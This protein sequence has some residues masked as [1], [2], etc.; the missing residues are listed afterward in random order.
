MSRA[1]SSIPRRTPCSGRNR[2]CLCRRLAVL[3]ELAAPSKQSD[4][5]VP[6]SH[7][8]LH[9]SAEFQRKQQTRG[10]M[11]WSYAAR[12]LG[13][14]G[15]RCSASHLYVRRCSRYNV[16]YN[17][18][19]LIPTV[20]NWRMTQNC[21]SQFRM[22]RLGCRQRTV[23]PTCFMRANVLWLRVRRVQYVCSMLEGFRYASLLAMHTSVRGVN[24]ASVFLLLWCR[25][26]DEA[27]ATPC[28][29]QTSKQA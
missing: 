24:R 28:S 1:G 12:F 22:C 10:V 11:C 19:R 9:C 27:V 17:A 15:R 23:C 20:V 4:V 3:W 14:I 13:G 6:R 5:F 29:Q 18:E 25:D 21:A 16:V 7:H 8:S 2:L 26:V